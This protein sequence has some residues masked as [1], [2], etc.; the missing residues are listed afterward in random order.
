M[1]RRRLRRYILLDRIFCGELAI[2]QSHRDW[3]D[4]EPRGIAQ[5]A[6]LT[7]QSKKLE[8]TGWNR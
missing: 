4:I 8:P 3:H 7:S 5:S 2:A 6:I 1:D